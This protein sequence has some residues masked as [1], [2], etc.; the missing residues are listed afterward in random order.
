MFKLVSSIGAAA[1][2][3]AALPMAAHA[4]PVGPYASLC[5][6][7]KPAILARVSGFKQATGTVAIKL[8]QSGPKFLEKGAYIRKVEVPVNRT[9]PI[10]VCVPVPA[11]GRYALSVRHEVTGD[12]SRADGGGFSGNPNMSL[13]DVVLKRKP[14]PNQVTFSV[15]DGTRV[16][17]VVLKYVQ[18]GSLRTAG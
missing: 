7:G 2:A 13:L 9:G 6:S 3:L 15:N 17:P 12:K 5:A 1:A 11:S 10:D 4:A 16:V 14:D 18:G 8:Y